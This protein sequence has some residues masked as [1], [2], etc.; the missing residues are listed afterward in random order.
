MNSKLTS[1]LKGLY[2]G[3][4]KISLKLTKASKGLKMHQPELCMEGINGTYFMKTDEGVN[5]GVFKPQD[6]EGSY[7]NKPKSAGHSLL[8][9]AVATASPSQTRKSSYAR[10]NGVNKGE[11]AQREVAAYLVDREHFYGVPSTT[12]VKL[13]YASLQ[14]NP[15][16]VTPRNSSLKI[17]SFQEFV[18]SDGS[19]EDMGVNSFPVHEVHKIG[20]LDLHIF[21]TDR[22]DGNVLFRETEDGNYVLTPID[23]G[24]SLPHSMENVYFGWVTWPQSKVPFDQETKAYIQ[25]IDVDKDIQM[26]KNQL[27]ITDDCL[28]IMKISATL[29]KK[30]A[31][32]NLTLQD[33]GKIASRSDCFDQPSELE[34]MYQQALEQ[35]KLTLAQTQQ[36]QGVSKQE[37]ED[38]LFY[39]TIFRLMDEKIQ[40]VAA[41][42]AS[43]ITKK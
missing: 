5:I 16:E 14:T 32:N 21:N 18:E 13:A 33:I 10:L 2:K 27:K 26:L 8:Q 42:N 3:S 11:A 37:E 39:E 31:A 24:L 28:R 17:G 19:V 25:R 41:R 6:E 35:T 43:N 22:H 20:I 30:G 7:L 9:S 15:E 34:V 1:R 36:P 38:E 29:L 40:S 4:P 12:M 23:H